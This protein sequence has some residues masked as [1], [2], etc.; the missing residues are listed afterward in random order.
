[1]NAPAGG[2]ATVGP[3]TRDAAT[4]EFFDAAGRGVFLL[5]RCQACSTVAEPR[6]RQC[7][8]CGS[9][10]LDWQPA[11]GGAR[12]L[13]W[14][15][16][17][18][19]PTQDGTRAQTVLAIGQLDEGPWWWAQVL[20][21]SSRDLRIGSPLRLDFCAVEGFEWVPVFRLADG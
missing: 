16:Q 13:S 15:V 8:E 11:A 1:M 3:V 9:T 19:R 5:R 18:G 21:A 4:A 14:A 7:P 6:V 17:H 2:A 10:N 12:V 20:D